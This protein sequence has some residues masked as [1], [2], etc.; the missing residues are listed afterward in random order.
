[1]IDKMHA[2]LVNPLTAVPR[3]SAVVPQYAQPTQST[4]RKQR[5]PTQREAPEYGVNFDS[6]RLARRPYGPQDVELDGPTPVH[7]QSVQEQHPCEVADVYPALGA[8]KPSHN[9]DARARRKPHERQKPAA[10]KE[11][12]LPRDT[13]APYI[14]T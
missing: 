14:Y 10:C 5:L 2:N 13:R 12:T 11:I 6:V 8:V 1:M 7:L 9:G 4:T 3:S